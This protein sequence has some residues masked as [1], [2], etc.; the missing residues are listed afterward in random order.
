MLYQ[1]SYYRIALAKV[2]IILIYYKYCSSRQR[3]R[4][5]PNGKK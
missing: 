2:G 3:N 4:I 5:N 1:L